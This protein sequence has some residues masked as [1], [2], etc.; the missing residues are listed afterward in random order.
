MSDADPTPTRTSTRLDQLTAALD[1]RDAARAAELDAAREDARREA[2]QAKAARA[3]PS[4]HDAGIGA[5]P[6]GQSPTSARAE[7]I[8]ALRL[9]LARLPEP[10]QL[11]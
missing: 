8:A 2:E 1:A 9:G 10:P 4:P 11:R 6:A 3:V 7:A 5:L